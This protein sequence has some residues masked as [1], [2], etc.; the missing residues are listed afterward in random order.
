M[1]PPLQGVIQFMQAN[2]PGRPISD[3]RV[4]GFSSP[5]DV[6]AWLMDNPERVL[7]GVHFSFNEAGVW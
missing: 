5:D 3:D 1:L 7:G 2:N 4:L 6:N